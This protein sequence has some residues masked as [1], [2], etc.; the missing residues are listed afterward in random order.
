LQGW[1]M[2]AFDHQRRSNAM[3]DSVAH[4]CARQLGIADAT[5][6]SQAD[7]KPSLVM[8][9]VMQPLQSLRR[10]LKRTISEADSVVS[11]V[12][13]AASMYSLMSVATWDAEA[14]QNVPAPEVDLPAVVADSHAADHLPKKL[15]VPRPGVDHRFFTGRFG[16]PKGQWM[17]WEEFYPGDLNNLTA[18]GLRT[19]LRALGALQVGNKDEMVCRLEKLRDQQYIPV[20]SKKYLPKGRLPPM[21]VAKVM[22]KPSTA[23]CEVG[24]EPKVAVHSP[25][26]TI[27]SSVQVK[28]VD[29]RVYAKLVLPASVKLTHVH[30]ASATT[31]DGG[32]IV[33]SMARAPMCS[34]PST[35]TPSTTGHTDEDDYSMIES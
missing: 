5:A 26:L 24:E 29:D 28:Y 15:F 25:W 4:V 20:L 14:N 7:A 19:R 6:G 3:A 33:L 12:S 1:A 10:Q 32:H 30:V 18:K 22:R 9:T 31:G 16:R 2:L 23:L 17:S 21:K 8:A 13:E 11:V 35:A 27:E 34:T